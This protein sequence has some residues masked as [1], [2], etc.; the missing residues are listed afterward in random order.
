MKLTVT[1]VGMHCGACVDTVTSAIRGLPG[2]RQCSV[3]V[4]E[5]QVAFDEKSV[6]K[7]DIFTAIRGAGS[8]DIAGFTVSD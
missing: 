7:S 2:V 1:I 3:R 8:F 4:G 6:A 5:A